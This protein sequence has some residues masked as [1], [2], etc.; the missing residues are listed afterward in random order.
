MGLIK[1]ICL[2]ITVKY[3][4]NKLYVHFYIKFIFTRFALTASSIITVL[5]LLN[6]L[7]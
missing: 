4:Q 3:S 5:K 1:Y 7:F 2:Y 6:G